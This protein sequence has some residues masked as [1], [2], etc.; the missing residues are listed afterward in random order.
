MFL[1]RMAIVEGVS[2]IVNLRRQ[3]TYGS[4][5][6]GPEADNGQEGGASPQKELG[7]GGFF[8]EEIPNS[9]KKSIISVMGKVTYVPTHDDE[10]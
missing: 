5:D 4:H 8:Q 10:R 7:P 2:G 1:S 9:E 3:S 6:V